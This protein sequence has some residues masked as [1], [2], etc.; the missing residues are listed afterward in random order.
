MEI[1]R[2]REG[3]DRGKKT[4]GNESEKGTEIGVEQ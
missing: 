2:E 1:G 3:R 4:R